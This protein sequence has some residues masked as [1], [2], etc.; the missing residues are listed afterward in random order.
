MLVYQRVPI[1]FEIQTS[2]LIPSSKRPP[3]PSIDRVNSHLSR[4]LEKLKAGYACCFFWF[5]GRIILCPKSRCF[6][7][8]M[9]FCFCG[10]AHVLFFLHF[11]SKIEEMWSC[12]QIEM[13]WTCVDKWLIRLYKYSISIRADL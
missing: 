1:S 7:L 9:F 11:W 3:A 10:N 8:M 4:L 5:P 12:I 13:V 6:V 2:H